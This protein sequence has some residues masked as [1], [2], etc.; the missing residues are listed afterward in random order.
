M[1]R[2]A[3]FTALASMVSIRSPPGHLVNLI[4]K[5]N[6]MIVICSVGLHVFH[7]VTQDGASVGAAVVFM[8]TAQADQGA[9]LHLQPPESLQ[10]LLYSPLLS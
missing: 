10:G 3:I 7:G 4:E 5:V 2:A 6:Q 1:I 8:P 9:G